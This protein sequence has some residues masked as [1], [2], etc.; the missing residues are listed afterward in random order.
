MKANGFNRQSSAPLS[1]EGTR[2]STCVRPVRTKIG[3]CGCFG[4]TCFRTSTPS[5]LG[6]FRSRINRWYLSLLTISEAASPS[7]TSWTLYASDSSC[8]RKKLASGT[9]SSAT[10]TCGFRVCRCISVFTG[11]LFWFQ[12]FIRSSSGTWISQQLP[13]CG[14]VPKQNFLMCRYIFAVH[15]SEP[16]WHSFLSSVFNRGVI[17]L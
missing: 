9:S 1:S 13:K 3:S 17:S 2:S 10:N 14:Q 15:R 6:K 8:R 16:V 7:C 12:S 4:R 5:S 11:Y